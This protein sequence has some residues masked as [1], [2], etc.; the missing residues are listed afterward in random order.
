MGITVRGGY[1]TESGWPADDSTG[2][3]YENDVEIPG[4]FQG[5]GRGFGWG[6]TELPA[7]YGPG[8][9][10]KPGG[11]PALVGPTSGQQGTSLSSVP[12]GGAAANQGDIIP[13]QH[14]PLRPG[15]SPARWTGGT[16]TEGTFSTRRA[17]AWV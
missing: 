17:N 5:G 9:F 6:D 2:I 13:P 12:P 1:N 15:M 8:G 16:S 7:K 11:V 3:Q 4:K 14:R 10:Y